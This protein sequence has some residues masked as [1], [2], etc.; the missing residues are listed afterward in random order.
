MSDNINK[1]NVYSHDLELWHH[2][3]EVGHINETCEQVMGRMD[4]IRF[5]KREFA[6]ELNGVTKGS[7][8]F[9]IVRIGVG[10]ERIIGTTKDRYHLI[11]PIEY[12]RLYDSST[13]Q[14]CETLGFLGTDAEKMFITSKLPGITVYGDEIKLYQFLAAGFDGLFGCKQYVTTVRVCCQNTANLAVSEADSTRNQGRGVLYSGKHNEVNHLRDLGLWLSH[15]QKQA[16]ETIVATQS[17]F[18]KMEETPMTVDQAFGLTTQIYPNPKP[19]P[20]FYPDALRVEKQEVID[21]KSEKAEESRDLVMDLFKG[22]GIEIS[23]T[24]YGLFNSVTEAENHHKPSK[25][26]SVYSL[27]LGNKH[28]IMSDAMAVISNWT[29]N[30]P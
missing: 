24:A 12:A 1:Q 2:K 4:E 15:V 18:C 5:E 11:Q 8:N 28:N 30:R 3:G 17:L 26:D 27:L 7:G 13:L 16:E 10:N 22:S 21:S 23:Q 20:D 29:V 14:Y 25:K 9:A 19:L 6:I